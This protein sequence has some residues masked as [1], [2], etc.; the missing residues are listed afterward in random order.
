[1]SF[2]LHTDPDSIFRTNPFDIDFFSLVSWT[3]DDALALLGNIAGLCDAASTIFL[4]GSNS[5][6]IDMIGF[7]CAAV[8]K[9]LTLFVIFV[10][11]EFSLFS[12]FDSSRQRWELDS[13]VLLLLEMSLWRKPFDRMITVK[14]LSLVSVLRNFIIIRRSTRHNFR[15]D[16]GLM[17]HQLT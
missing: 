9:L 3:I 17:L 7:S 15:D 13:L 16:A 14:I 12:L 10:L 2:L 5:E 6:R 8:V 4:N 1:M 11:L